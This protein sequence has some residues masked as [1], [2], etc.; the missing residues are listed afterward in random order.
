MPRAT[1]NGHL[2]LSLVSCPVYLTPAIT[3]TKRIRLNQ[4]NAATG[5]RLKQQL[6]D[7]ETGKVVERLLVAKGYEYERGQYVLISDEELKALQVESS[8]VISLTRFVDRDDVDSVY[9]DTPYYVYPDGKLAVEAFQ[10][11]GRAMA[12]K[13]LAGLGSVTIA[14]R[15]RQV[16]VEPRGQGLVM[17]TLRAAD[18][19]RPSEFAI[20]DTGAIDPDMLAIAEQIIERARG[21][22]DPGEFH[23]TY[24]DALRELVDAKLKGV[25]VTPRK[26][27]PL[28]QVPDL[29]EAL[30]RSLV[31][32]GALLKTARKRSKPVDRRQPELLMPVAGGRAKNAPAVAANKP[33]AAAVTAKRRKSS[34]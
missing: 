33:P 32:S 5:N 22:F 13:G 15:E 28:P 10:I 17:S 27:A 34:G 25:A 30:K 2:R 3:E 6:V 16:L 23:D 4:I 19:V 9:L 29:M 8:K 12:A 14:S 1:W 21:V 7:S 26:I 18:E 20:P 24:Q 11:I 31:E